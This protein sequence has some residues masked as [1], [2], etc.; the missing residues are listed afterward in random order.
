MD[1]RQIMC[2]LRYVSSYLGVFPSD[3][4]PQHFIARSGTL[5]VNTDPHTESGSHW[6]AIHFQ[7]RSHSSYYFD[8]YGLPPYIISIQSF[9]RRNSSVWDYNA[10]QLQGPTSTVCAKY[11]C[12]FALDM[13]R[14]YTP[15]QFVGLL[16]TASAD[17]LVADMFESE[18]GPLPDISRGGQC[19]GSRNT[20]Y[21]A[22]SN[23]P[24]Y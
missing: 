19:S 5:V 14:G 2:C 16:A 20:T 3:L 17:K 4:L 21:V 13:D 7:P 23:F 18:F 22:T 9:L 15:K 11:C 24:H 8:R 12:L 10:V 1:T 6:I